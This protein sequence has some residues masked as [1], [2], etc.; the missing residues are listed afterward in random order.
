MSAKNIELYNEIQKKGKKNKQRTKESLREWKECA[1]YEIGIIFNLKC[2]HLE[3]IRIDI[4]L[5]Y[6]QNS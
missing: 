1:Q 2:E 3:I 4:M 5:R 6:S